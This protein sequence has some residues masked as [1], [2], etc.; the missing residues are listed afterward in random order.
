MQ[1]S[2]LRNFTWG[3]FLAFTLPLA[4]AERFFGEPVALKGRASDCA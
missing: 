1:S 3:C 2:F 4:A